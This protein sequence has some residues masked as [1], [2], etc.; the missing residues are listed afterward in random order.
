MA[1]LILCNGKYYELD[2]R[3]Y[4]SLPFD[5]NRVI[6]DPEHPEWTYTYKECNMHDV[7]K[8]GFPSLKS[9]I[10]DIKTGIGGD[11]E[12]NKD[13]DVDVGHTP[14]MHLKFRWQYR[15]DNG[16]PTTEVGMALY[17]NKEPINNANY[18]A[19]WT[20]PGGSALKYGFKICAVKLLP[21][22]SVLHHS[23]NSSAIGI[24]L[25]TSEYFS[26]R[27]YKSIKL[28]AGTVFDL[29]NQTTGGQ[30]VYKSQK[31]STPKKD[32]AAD[33][34]GIT[35]PPTV[36]PQGEPD[37]PSINIISGT[38]ITLSSPTSDE[39]KQLN[40]FLWSKSFYDNIL[41]IQQDPL[42]AVLGLYI[43]DCPIP[44]S[45]RNE[46]V[47]GNVDTGISANAILQSFMVVDCGEITVEEEYGSYLDYSPFKQAQ[48]YLP[49]IGFVDIDNDIIQNNT[50]HIKYHV[51]LIDGQ[52]LCYVSIKQNRYPSFSEVYKTYPC[53]VYSQ[54][55]M[56]AYDVT[57]KMQSFINTVTSSVL[58]F[59]NSGS[60]GALTSAVGGAVSTAM[61]KNKVEKSG[62][63]TDMAGLMGMKRPCLILYTTPAYMPS[64][65]TNDVGSLIGT[66]DTI[67]NV[68]G[69]CKIIN[70]R[71]NFSCPKFVSDKLETMLANGVIWE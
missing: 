61:T 24:A 68:G 51:S 34:G 43:T 42:Q 12:L 55:P 63:L 20:N 49:H 62:A 38:G 45:G 58:S 44:T 30:I 13:W 10:Y 40:R 37:I 17:C 25:W 16:K 33:E 18:D 35:T 46:I 47:C 29:N 14:G 2:T 60:A 36:K 19:F 64:T 70:P 23:K 54:V 4:N 28:F 5:S 31:P 32:G 39:I 26:D 48:L 65:Y 56:S 67:A 7:N 22:D 9:T 1:D 50:I 6:P 59:A 21:S 11:L 41:K 69:L 8:G 15:V 66:S 3:K 52:A 57:A 27:T 53:S 71:I